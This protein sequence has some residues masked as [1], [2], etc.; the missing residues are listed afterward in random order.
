[1]PWGV[2]INWSMSSNW[3]QRVQQYPSPELAWEI[4][5]APC[6]L[7]ARK[8]HLPKNCLDSTL[9]II[10]PTGKPTKTFDTTKG[11]KHSKS[12]VI[13][14]LRSLPIVSH[15]EQKNSYANSIM[16]FD[17]QLAQQEILSFSFLCHFATK[18][19]APHI[20]VDDWFLNIFWWSKLALPTF[21]LNYVTS[22]PEKSQTLEPNQL[23]EW[24]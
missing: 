13:F 19:A 9:R 15:T 6:V 7:F 16:F 4:Q 20:K 2:T 11:L 22:H 12:R 3:H 8:L 5:L 14:L 10:L 18:W 17:S 24:A 1:M 21:Q 23:F